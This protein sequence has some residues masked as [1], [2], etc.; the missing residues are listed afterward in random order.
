MGKRVEKVQGMIDEHENKDNDLKEKIASMDVELKK[1]KVHTERLEDDKKENSTGDARLQEE[2][3]RQIELSKNEENRIESEKQTIENELKKR[4]GSF[5]K[6]DEILASLTQE[7]ASLEKE[8]RKIE[9]KM[10]SILIKMDEFEYQYDA[11]GKVTNGED[12]AKLDKQYK[13][14]T[15]EKYDIKDAIKLCEEYLQKY[16]DELD[17][18]G[19]EKYGLGKES[20]GVEVEE[21]ESKEEA[22]E[23]NKEVE[24]PN[25]EEDKTKEKTEKSEEDKEEKAKETEN[26]NTTT[27]PPAKPAQPINSRHTTQH[28]RSTE[29]TNQ[30][31]PIQS[32]GPKE[33]T[34][35]ELAKP[36]P[37]KPQPKI[38]KITFNTHNNIPT[39]S[40]DI[41]DENGKAQSF[42]STGF[43]CVKVLNGEVKSLLEKNRND[44]DIT[45]YL[46]LGLANILQQVDKKYGTTGLKQYQQML[47]N[48]EKEIAKEDMLDIEYDFSELYK[49]P[50]I[51]EELKKIQ[52]KG[53][54]E[55]IDKFKRS[56]D[57]ARL[58]E[59]QKIAKNNSKIG[60][61]QYEKRPNFLKRLWNQIATLKIT[62]GKQKEEGKTDDSKRK[63]K[64]VDEM[65][66]QYINEKDTT[67]FD[68]KIF[69]EQINSIEGVGLEEKKELLNRI[70]KASEP[71]KKQE[72]EAK[73]KTKVPKLK[74]EK[75]TDEEKVAKEV[76]E[77]VKKIMAEGKEPEKD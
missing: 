67:G 51:K 73:Y 13:K 44:K 71:T 58:K 77:S 57:K 48:R 49:M 23:P 20:S 9:V 62:D 37:K 10:Q 18:M 63:E 24:V 70:A 8:K 19:E 30:E 25:K 3:D 47:D 27:T 50:N 52:D 1:A 2:Y 26:A 39:Y 31:P 65:Y 22:D 34:K 40:I 56:N 29:P 28:S 74:K 76:G 45:K 16:H 35:P 72:F 32:N 4:T 59:L 14:L 11:E 5:L 46:D 43:E 55:E 53:S 42:V 17:K 69:E 60:L 36:E 64:W 68:A 33:R 75:D 12:Y 66:K 61:A 6:H 38:N 21:A 7:K 54:K 41:I 15:D